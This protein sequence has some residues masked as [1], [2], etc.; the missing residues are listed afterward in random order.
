M[1]SGTCRVQNHMQKHETTAIPDCDC[2]TFAG[3]ANR[4]TFADA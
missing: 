1:Q 4:N 3:G 2:V